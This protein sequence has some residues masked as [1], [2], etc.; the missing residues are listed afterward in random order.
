[1]IDRDNHR[2]IAQLS[3]ITIDVSDL[4]L[5]K[6]LLANGIGHGNYRG[7][8]QVGDFQTTTEMRGPEFTAGSRS[9]NR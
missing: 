2:P 3:G 9:Q 7:E 5:E 4:E 8:R 6:K 1:M